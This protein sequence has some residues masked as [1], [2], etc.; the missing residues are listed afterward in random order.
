[1]TIYRYV[2][3]HNITGL[4]YLGKTSRADPHAYPGSGIYWLRHLKKYGKDYSTIILKE[5]HSSSEI[6]EWGLYYSN[7]WNVVKSNEWA[8]LIKEE[9]SGGATFGFLG[10]NHS[11]ESIEKI[12]ERSKGILKSEITKTKMKENH[13]GF[14]G[15]EHTANT[16]ALIS[17]YHK[18]KKI[19]DD[20]KEKIRAALRGRPKT[21]EH[22]NKLKEKSEKQKKLIVTPDGIFNSRADAALF[23][24]IAPESM[25]GRIKRHPEKYYYILNIK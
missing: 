4:K 18:N 19:S 11:A 6:K 3:T 15:K 13:V 12:K 24:N 14:S 25:G 21:T 7:L 9:G 10:K 23:Y 8:N 22:R 17:D 16:K 1:M 5:C 20:H 2:K